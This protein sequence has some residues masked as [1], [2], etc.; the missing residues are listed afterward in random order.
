MKQQK[1]VGAPVLAAPHAPPL[2]ILRLEQF[3]DLQQTLLAVAGDADA[4]PERLVHAVAVFL[5]VEGTAVGIVED[6]RYRLLATHGLDPA[7]RARFD[8]L[9]AHDEAVGAALAES[10][11]VVLPAAGDTDPGPTLLLPFGT[12]APPGDPSGAL[13]GAL[14][15]IPPAAGLP[16]EDVNLAQAIAV[17]AGVALANAR[18]ARRLARIARLKGDALS[19]MAHDLRAPLNALIGYT[20][21]LGEGA[22]GALTEEQREVAATLERQAIELVDLLGATLDVARLETGRLPLRI[23]TFGLPD[24]LAALGAGTFARASQDGLIVWRA[25]PDLPPLRSDRVKV[26]EIV[27]N[28]VDNAL[29]YH[30]GR[31][32]EVDVGL[33][34]D[35]G[36]VRITVRDRGPG[37]AAEVLPRLFEPFSPGDG[38]STGFGLYIVRC[39]AEA[40]GGRVAARSEPGEGTAVTVELPLAAPVR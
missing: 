11:P 19:T 5:G 32:V 2:D 3:L 10:R 20:S 6:G 13:A 31:G 30:A 40:L 9:A 16:D 4:L 1:S 27:Q 14:H 28:L 17:L 7:Y 25:A 8:G 34:P 18:Q 33:A 35:A 39:L 23:E 37:I 38:R 29:K 36:R 12:L 24:V 21:L 15:V 26:K 22:F